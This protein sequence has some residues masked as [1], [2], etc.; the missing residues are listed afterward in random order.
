MTVSNFQYYSGIFLYMY[1]VGYHINMIQYKTIFHT[2]LQWLRS[3]IM[4]SQSHYLNQYW[5]IITGV[6]WYLL[7]RNFIRTAHELNPQHVFG[8]HIFLNHYHM[9]CPRY[10]WVNSLW[11]SDAIGHHKSGSS[12]AQVMVCCLMAPSHYLNKRWLLISDVWCQSP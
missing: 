5:L 3:Y 9:W 1:R 10:Q 4:T 12:L 7:E 11:P 6:L 2:A 8:H